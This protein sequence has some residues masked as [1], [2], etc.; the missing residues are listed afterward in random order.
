MSFRGLSSRNPPRPRRRSPRLRGPFQGT[1]AGS[2]TLSPSAGR[3]AKFSVTGRSLRVPPGS[4]KPRRRCRAVSYLCWGS[5]GPQSHPQTRRTRSRSLGRPWAARGGAL[6][7]LR[8]PATDLAS[9]R[10][11]EQWETP[12]RDTRVCV[13]ARVSELGLRAVAML[14]K[15]RRG[16]RDRAG[17]S[18]ARRLGRAERRES[19]RARSPAGT[20]EGWRRGSGRERGRRQS[21]EGAKQTVGGSG[22]ESEGGGGR[23]ERP[24]RAAPRSRCAVQGAAPRWVLA[25]ARGGSGR[26]REA[27]RVTWRSLAR[28]SI[29]VFIV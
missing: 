3:D 1:K 21:R 25:S 26:L 14:R 4:C 8:L 6:L 10:A 22:M 5:R 27:G 17:G 24:G 7:R 11:C 18:A 29:V 19:L 12:G 2:P 15:P 20:G 9:P 23:R 28:A 13:C 16:D